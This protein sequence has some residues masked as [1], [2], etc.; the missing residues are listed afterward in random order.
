M[1]VH[2]SKSHFMH[3]LARCAAVA[4]ALAVGLLVA[5]CRDEAGPP[6]E[7]AIRALIDR[8]EQH[9]ENRDIE[10]FR[11]LI[12]EDYKDTRG[13]NRQSVLLMLNYYFSANR[14]IH[15]LTRAPQVHF[16][17]SSHADVLVFVAMAGRPIAGP[18]QLSSLNADL[19][20]VYASVA[21]EG[22]EWKITSA[23]WARGWE[24]DVDASG[25][26]RILRDRR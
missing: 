24:P 19:Y 11:N 13:N 14:S 2:G 9:A 16:T 5:A 23:R 22:D 25:A 15:L 8:A 20:H 17:D 7:E 4:L 6:V 1:Q 26:G 10:S 12:S 3:P 21:E 18:D